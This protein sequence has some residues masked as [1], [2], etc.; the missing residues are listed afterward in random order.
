MVHLLLIVG[1]RF[2]LLV[3]NI[4]KMLLAMGARYCSY[5]NNPYLENVS[6]FFLL[7]P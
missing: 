3:S 6:V 7:A 4:G 5:R 1:T 2:A